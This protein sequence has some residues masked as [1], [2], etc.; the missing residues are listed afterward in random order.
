MTSLSYMTLGK[1]A[2]LMIYDILENGSD[3]AT[4]P[5][6]QSKETILY[7][8]QDVARQL[9]ITLSEAVLANI[10]ER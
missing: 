10:S 9:G 6:Y 4:L 1:Q 8:N 5:V 3:I 2:G 7:V